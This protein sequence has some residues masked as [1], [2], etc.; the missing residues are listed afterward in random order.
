MSDVA[1]DFV[2]SP[3]SSALFAEQPANT[4]TTKRTERTTARIFFVSFI[5][6]TSVQ[7]NQYYY[8]VK[9]PNNQNKNAISL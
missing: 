5:C 1:D 6:L 2:F 8:K 7:I 4:P 9:T 3:L